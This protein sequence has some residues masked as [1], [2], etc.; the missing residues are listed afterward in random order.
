MR[1]EQ[2]RGNRELAV[3]STDNA[4]RPYVDLFRQTIGPD[5]RPRR[6]CAI[7]NCRSTEDPGDVART[8][9]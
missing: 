6:R 5:G 2:I 1:V 8:N 4:G 7:I 9:C 3:A